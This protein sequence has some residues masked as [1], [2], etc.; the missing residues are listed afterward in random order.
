MLHIFVEGPDDERFFNNIYGSY[1][2]EFKFI[3]YAGWPSAKINNF[4]RSICCMENCDYLF[5]GD[6]DGKTIE[7]KTSILINRYPNL[8][9][10]KVFIVQ[11]EIESWYYAGVSALVCQKLNLKQYVHNTDNLTKE[12]FNS[13]IPKKADRKYIMAEILK[14]YELQLAIGRNTSLAIFDQGIKKEPA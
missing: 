14:F 2:D 5:L 10:D 12:H 8:E 6:A 11:Y 7:D 9:K 13:K 3:K 4:I 1:W